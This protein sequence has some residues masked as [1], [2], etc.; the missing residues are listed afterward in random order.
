M[1]TLG[2]KTIWRKGK[3]SPCCPQHK[4]QPPISTK[5]PSSSPCRLGEWFFHWITIELQI[6]VSR[7]ATNEQN[8]A[9]FVY[10]TTARNDIPAQEPEAVR[11]VDVTIL[12]PH[13][14]RRFTISQS[15]K[16]RC[17]YL[18]PLRYRK[19]KGRTFSHMR[20]MCGWLVVLKLAAR[21][22]LWRCWE[23]I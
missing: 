14:A 6:I 19:M 7:K 2:S 8:V 4:P 10:G 12:V 23:D 5:A 17:S 9:Q 16:S 15:Q 11:G 20:R 13:Q 18:K 21:G 22:E 3:L 1:K